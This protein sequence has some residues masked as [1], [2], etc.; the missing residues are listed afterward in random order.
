MCYTLN[1]IMPLYSVTRF[2]LPK[3]T[4]S[5]TS[6]VLQKLQTH[7]KRLSSLFAD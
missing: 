3:V 5:V 7:M 6:Y 2:I 1:V 4:P